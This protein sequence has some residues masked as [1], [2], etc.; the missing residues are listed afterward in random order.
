[1][2]RQPSASIAGPN[3]DL[4]LPEPRSPRALRRGL[5]VATAGLRTPL[6]NSADWL[7][8]DGGHPLVEAELLRKRHSPRPV[9]YD[10]PG[11]NNARYRNLLTT[12]ESLVFAA[13]TG[14]PW[15][16]LRDL[17]DPN[18]LERALDFVDESTRLS[19]TVSE[20]RV[21]QRYVDDLCELGDALL[22]DLGALGQKLPPTYCE[23]L[24]QAVVKRGREHGTPVLILPM[25]RTVST[26]AA[27]ERGLVGQL[28]AS[29]AHGLVLTT[30]TQ[31]NARAQEAVDLAREL[32]TRSILTQGPGRHSARI[33][34]DDSSGWT[35][36]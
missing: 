11:A 20:P 21:L 26:G 18:D 36:L 28:L 33:L 14:F 31:H 2:P 25:A 30:E 9:I 13:S 6:L 5:V 32:V 10:I 22:L 1:M 3:R 16:N 24:T 12:T 19:C 35:N 17:E 15:V 23:T 29:G 8:V 4:P 34:D 27:A 7:R